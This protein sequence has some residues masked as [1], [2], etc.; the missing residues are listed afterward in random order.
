M[1]TREIAAA[2]SGLA[3]LGLLV[4]LPHIQHGGLYLDDWADAA[5]TLHPPGDSGLL[6]ALSHFNEVLSSS[7]PV[8]IAFIPLKYLLFGTHIKALL[9]LSVALA[10]LAAALM[11]AVLRTLSLPWYHAWL[12]SALTI[13]YPWFDSTRFWESANPITLAVVLLFA[14]MWMALHGLTQES[15]RLHAVAAFLY[16]LSMLAYEITLPFV[17]ALGFLYLARNGWRAARFRWAADLVMVAIA[18][19]WGKAH[20]PK[21]VSSLSGDITHLEQIV[22]QGKELFARTAFPVGNQPHTSAIA[23][24]FAVVFAFGIGVYLLSLNKRDTST[25]Q[26]LRNWL[27]LAIFGLFIAILGWA[28]F[29]PADPYYTPSVFGATNRVNGFAGFGL[30]LLVYSLIGVGVTLVGRLF[31]AKSWMVAGVTVT[32]GLC[33]GAAYIHV[34]ER[35][36]RLWDDS[37]NYQLGAIEQI[38]RAFP[39]PSPGTTVFAGGYPANITL[40]VPIFA[41]TWDLSGMVKLTYADSTLRAYPITEELGVECLRP[42]MRP[43]G[44]EGIPIAR[45]GTTRL[46]NLTTGQTASPRTRAECR[47]DTSQYAPGPLYLATAY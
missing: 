11:Y 46:I 43:T 27:F 34:L 16:L 4:F 38:H 8:L 28:I 45:Y 18:G 12:I 41:A 19:I 40:G 7:R 23:G 36:G 22:H 30:V 3:I 25:S 31:K 10:V 2:W 13:A 21:T 33:L 1:T 37:Y 26:S 9:I 17:A 20:T 15:W 47:D 39:N 6:P 24:A 35:H 29:I 5:L 42:G 14:G 32:L 44:E